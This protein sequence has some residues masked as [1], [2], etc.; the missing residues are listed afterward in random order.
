MK[1]TQAML[2]VE[3]GNCTYPTR[4][5][6][7]AFVVGLQCCVLS[8]AQKDAKQW[9]DEQRKAETAWEKWIQSGKSQPALIAVKIAPIHELV[10]AV[11]PAKG[12]QMKR[13]ALY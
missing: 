7:F 8:L 6:T 11:D 4:S 2:V 3:I 10:M 9:E 12:K 13:C 5:A 1:E